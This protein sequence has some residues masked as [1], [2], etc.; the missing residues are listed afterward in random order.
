M[1]KNIHKY[2]YFIKNKKRPKIKPSLLFI[3]GLFL[4]FTA[5]NRGFVYCMFYKEISN[6]SK[7]IKPEGT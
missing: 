5:K 2:N 1:K 3:F 4:A 6:I 7:V